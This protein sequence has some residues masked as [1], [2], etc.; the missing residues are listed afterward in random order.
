MQ[1]IDEFYK[2]WRRLVVLG[3]TDKLSEEY[4]NILMRK[5]RELLYVPV[6]LGPGSFFY[7]HH[8]KTKGY[9]SSYFS[10]YYNEVKVLSTMVFASMAIMA[11]TGCLFIYRLHRTSDMIYEECLSLGMFTQEEIRIVEDPF[12]LSSK[13]T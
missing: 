5:T 13:E 11:V 2:S 3:N 8:L 9:F 12:Y 4:Q 6:V 10:A 1:Y 7:M